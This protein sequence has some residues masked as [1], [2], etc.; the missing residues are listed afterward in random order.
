MRRALALLLLTLTMACTAP[1][2]GPL[3]GPDAGTPDG[4]STEP[5]STPASQ[6]TWV[7]FPETR[8]G[9]GTPAGVGLNP[10]PGG[11]RKVLLFLAGGGACW[12]PVTCYVLKTAVHVEDTYTQALLETEVAQLTAWGLTDRQDETSPFRDAH[13]VYVPYCTGDLHVGDAVRSYDSTHPQRQLH[14]RGA[15]NMD[16]FLLRLKATFPDAEQLWLMGSSAGGYG[17]Q[18][19]FDRV[20]LA[21]SGARV[22]LLAD[23]AQLVMPYGGR[24]GEMRN[25]WNPRLPSECTECAQD[26]PKL[27]DTLATR[28]PGRRLGLLAYDN[29]ATLTLYFNYPLGGMLG[30][31]QSLLANQYTHDRARYFVLGGTD[32]VLLSGYKSLVGP[33]GVS[34]KSWV[35]QWATG[36]PAWS[37]VR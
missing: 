5:I 2:P 10:A 18:L 29:D 30:A 13:F 37:N 34:L 22:D 14:H 21:F 36:D 28:W 25:A 16:A 35:Q 17:A 11:S 24:W 26:L 1:A 27:L 12:D 3:P 33:G 19:S 6:W 7:P 9:N 8:C 20:S 32:H 31:T 23:S 15:S 4:G